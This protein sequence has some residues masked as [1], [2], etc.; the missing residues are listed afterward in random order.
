[1]IRNYLK[2]AWR[3]IIKQKLYSLINITGLASGLAVCM[4]IMLYVAHEMSYDHF[5]KNASRIFIPNASIKVNGNTLNMDYTSFSSGPYVKE[6]EP[7]V[8]D[9][10]RTFGYYNTVVAYNPAT[11]QAKYAEKDLLFADANFFGFF[12]FK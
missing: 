10:S 12:S 3:N 7:V 4:M 1:M 5:H 11:P 9:Y 2:I 6:N 8:E